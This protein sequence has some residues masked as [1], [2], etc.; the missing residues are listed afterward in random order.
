MRVNDIYDYLNPMFMSLVN[1]FFKL[2]R[3][4]ETRR[5]TEKVG[6]VVAERTIIRMLH[7]THD[8]NHIVAQFKH[9]WNHSVFEIS[10]GVDFE[11][12][13]THTDVG[14]VD[15]DVFVLPVGSG[16]FEV[17]ILQ[18]NVHAIEGFVLVLDGKVDPGRDSVLDLTSTKLDL[19][20]YLGE[21][22]DRV[23]ELDLAIP[24]A[25]LFLHFR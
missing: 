4:T 1:H 14:L 10:E 23:V 16:I 18:V 11:F 7:N 5:N 22:F 25:E 19:A 3:L 2:I 15:L 13:T 6:D 12:F 17:V 24:V 21:L 20:F 8:L 9:P